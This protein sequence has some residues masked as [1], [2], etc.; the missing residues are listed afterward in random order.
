[1]AINLPAALATAKEAGSIFMVELYVLSLP[2]GPMYLCAADQDVTF[3]GQLYHA[4]PLE[5]DVYK[6]SSDSKVDDCKLKVSNFDDSFTAALFSGFDFRGCNCSI[7]QI[8]YPDALSDPTLVKPILSGYLDAPVLT[9]KDATFEVAVKAQVPN[10]SNAR[11]F[12]LSC[13]ANFAD[14]ESCF[15]VMDVKTG[16]VQSGTTG[17]VIVL[18]H[19]YADNYWTDGIITCGFQGRQVLSSTGNTVTLLFP[20]SVVPTGNYSIQNGCDKSWNGCGLKGQ[21]TNYSGFIGI[22]YETVVREY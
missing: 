3:N 18:Q 15:A 9:Q 13:N 7:F 8:L 5:R 4:V 19:S 12:Q 14:Q 11:T 2:N 21:Q 6:A 17:S 10:L 1:M 20:F 16:T 22:P